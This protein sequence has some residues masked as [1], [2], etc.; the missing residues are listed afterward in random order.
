MKDLKKWKIIIG[1]FHQETNSFCPVNWTLEHFKRDTFLRGQE[2]L[3]NYAAPSGRILSGILSE[4]AEHDAVAIPGCAIRATSGGAVAAEVVKYYTQEML[5]CIHENPDVDALILSFHGATQSVWTD[6]VCGNM[7][8]TF[9]EAVGEKVLIAFGCDMHANITE[10]CCHNADIICGFQTYPHVDQFQTGVRAAKLAFSQLNGGK[11]LYRATVTI[12]MILP[13]C[14][15][16]TIRGRFAEIMADG[17]QMVE[18]GYLTDFSLFQMQPWLDVDPAGS[19]VLTIAEDPE[20]AALCAKKLAQELYD[21]REEFSAQLV[22][23]EEVIEKA[24]TVPEGHPVILVDAADSPGGGAIGDSIYVVD[25]LRKMDY[26]V[27]TAIIVTDPEVANKAHKLGIGTTAVFNLGGKI[28]P[29]SVQMKGVTATVKGLYDGHFIQ[30]GPVGKG[31]PRN[32]GRS[33]ILQIENVDVLVCEHLCGAGDLQAYRTFDMEPTNYQLVVVKAHGSF[34]A[35]YEPFASEICL[36]DTPGAS[37]TD[38]LR[39]KYR[40]LPQYFYPFK[41][42]GYQVEEPVIW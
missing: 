30:E 39:L 24:K 11:K 38:L 12:P 34:R 13:A 21:N 5:Q 18:D 7:L 22:P 4:I 6:D 1:D 23:V 41:R 29:D 26:P 31:Q 27:K 25:C 14:G 36:S 3:D 16:S 32:M 8:A 15:Y 19:T 28:T 42:E 37:M 33:A 9:R 20:K 17:H 35:G 40:H 10:E 2:V